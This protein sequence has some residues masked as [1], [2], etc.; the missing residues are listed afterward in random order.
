MY[1]LVRPIGTG[2]MGSIYEAVNVR[3]PGRRYAVKVL[4]PDIARNEEALARFRREAEIATQLGHPHI[5][6]VHDFNIEG[7]VP[8]IVMEL[9]VGEDLAARL[10]RG[11]LDLDTIARIVPEIASALDAA[12]RAGV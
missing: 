5:V 2:G 4:H 10:Q 3:L 7:G 8:Y 9:L 11:P 1:Q 6:E 12:H